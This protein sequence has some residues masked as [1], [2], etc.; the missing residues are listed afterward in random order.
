MA[1]LQSLFRRV[2]HI[3]APDDPAQTS[4]DGSGSLVALTK[5]M[6]GKADASNSNL[7]A[8]EAL[9]TTMSAQN[10]TM[11]ANQATIISNQ[12]LIITAVNEVNDTLVGGINVSL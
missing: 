7:E 10:A 8:L 4:P 11:I 6:M 12:A 5:G 1:A 2:W 3:G 9:L